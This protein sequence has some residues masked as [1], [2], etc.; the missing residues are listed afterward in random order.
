MIICKIIYYFNIFINM[1]IKI[2]EGYFISNK[3]II[4]KSNKTIKNL[5]IVAHP[6]DELLFFGDLLITYYNNI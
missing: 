6:D 1:F 4:A 2:K 3:K 5:I